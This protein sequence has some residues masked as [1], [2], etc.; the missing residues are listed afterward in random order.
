MLRK[1]GS[2]LDSSVE[3]R[4]EG[5]K[6]RQDL[7]PS[8]ESAPARYVELAL[9]FD[10]IAKDLSEKYEVGILTGASNTL[11][12]CITV[13]IVIPSMAGSVV[14]VIKKGQ[15]TIPKKLREKHRIGKKALAIDTEE[16][17]S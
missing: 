15:A 9:T 10:P 4:Y 14:T 11:C 7:G 6:V 13:G 16:G 12:L 5:A 1:R 2:A 3:R 8:A 17:G